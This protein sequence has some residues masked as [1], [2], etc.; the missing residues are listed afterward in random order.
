MLTGPPPRTGTR[1]NRGRDEVRLD[2]GPGLDQDLLHH[3]VQQ[4]LELLGRSV[5]HG[6]LDPAPNPQQD[7]TGRR[8]RARLTLGLQ[9]RYAGLQRPRFLLDLGKAV[10]AQIDSGSRPASK[11]RR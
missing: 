10:R 11:A 8:R 5:G 2:A 4:S 6:A 9:R 7:L 1:T 3:R